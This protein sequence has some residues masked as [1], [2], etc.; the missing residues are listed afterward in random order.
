[1]SKIY[2]NN[3]TNYSLAFEQLENIYKTSRFDVLVKS[4]Y[5]LLFLKE[6]RQ[7]S[8]ISR[9][10]MIKNIEKN[11]LKQK[12]DAFNCWYMKVQGKKIFVQT[13]ALKINQ[14]IDKITNRIYSESFFAIK[15]KSIDKKIASKIGRS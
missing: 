2:K 10:I 15:K 8:H 5:S 11:I 14:I 7:L 6:N 1:M 4:F 12:A 3:K 13:G 9:T